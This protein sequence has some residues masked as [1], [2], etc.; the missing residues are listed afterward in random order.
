M[1]FKMGA[2]QRPPENTASF[3][4]IDATKGYVA[5]NVRIICKRANTMLSDSTPEQRHRLAHWILFG[6]ATGVPYLG[7]ATSIAEP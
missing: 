1:E 5:G 7:T 2:G 4:R 6:T 3:D